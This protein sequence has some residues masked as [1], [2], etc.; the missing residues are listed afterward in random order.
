MRASAYVV[1]VVFAIF[2][3]NPVSPQCLTEDDNRPGINTDL[4]GLANLGFNL[5]RQ[6][7]PSGNFFF[8]PYS[9]WS[10]LGMTYLGSG[11][12]TETQLQTALGVTDKLNTYRLIN[13]LRTM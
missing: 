13:S 1:L 8:S 10:A 11:G 6:I 9:I 12:R 5:Y 7:N 2:F 4:S 3:N